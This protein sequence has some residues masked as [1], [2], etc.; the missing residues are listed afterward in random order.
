MWR[1]A[2]RELPVPQAKRLDHPL[3]VRPGM[4]VLAVLKLLVAQEV[5]EEDDLRVPAPELLQAAAAMVP[6]RTRVA[7]Q[8]E[9]SA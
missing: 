3:P 1:P 8:A 4:V 5:V 7:G 6:G 9:H 2:H